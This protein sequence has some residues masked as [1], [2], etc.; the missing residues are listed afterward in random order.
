[1]V[2]FVEQSI[3]FSMHI[4]GQSYREKLEALYNVSLFTRFF[5][6]WFMNTFVKIL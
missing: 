5:D 1:M 4:C 3:E 2:E 6:G